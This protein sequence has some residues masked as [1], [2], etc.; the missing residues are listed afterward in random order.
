MEDNVDLLHQS[1][2]IL[3]AD[4]KPLHRDVAA[5][6][7]HLLDDLGLCLLDDIEQL[8]GERGVSKG[9]AGSERE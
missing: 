4:A 9:E 8:N 5:H 3:V 7:K 6:R 1:R 2:F